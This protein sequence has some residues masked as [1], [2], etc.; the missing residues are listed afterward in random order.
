MSR[1]IRKKPYWAR[2]GRTCQA[3]RGGRY[4][5]RIAPPSSGGIGIRLNSPRIRLP[6]TMKT[7]IVA[8]SREA[9]PPSVGFAMSSRSGI[10]KIAAMIRFEIGPATAT[11]ASPWRPRRLRG[12][13]GV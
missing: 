2:N 10:A 12:L 13:T 4:E 1:M 3:V 8:I 5:S 6:W 7:R 9:L 11:T